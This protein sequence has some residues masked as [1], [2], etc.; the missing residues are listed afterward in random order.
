MADEVVKEVAP[1]SPAFDPKAVEAMV[2][3]AVRTSIESLMKESQ[4][5]QAEADAAQAAEP[6]AA[7]PGPFDDMFK[8][9]LDPVLKSVRGAEVAASMAMD[10]VNFYQDPENQEALPF[11]GKIEG[12]ISGQLKKGNVISRAD[13]WNWL[14]GGELKKDIRA[15][16]ETAH[17]AKLKAANEATAA[18]PSS[19]VVKFSKPMDEMKTD[20]LG[21]ALK[22]VTF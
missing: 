2:Q 20:E 14:Q 13:A 1:A 11:R 9:A 12:V 15:G 6:K 8:P 22:G 5:K 10:A 16:W 3:G 18:G 4:A 19:S 7:Q 21:D 17:A